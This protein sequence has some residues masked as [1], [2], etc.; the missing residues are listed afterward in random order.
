MTPR[1]IGWFL[2]LQ[3]VWLTTTAHIAYPELTLKISVNYRPDLIFVSIWCRLLQPLVQRCRRHSWTSLFPSVRLQQK[4][5]GKKSGE[6]NDCPIQN[7]SADLRVGGFRFWFL[8]DFENKILI[9]VIENLWSHGWGKVMSKRG[10]RT[11]ENQRKTRKTF[12]GEMVNPTGEE[13]GVPT[14]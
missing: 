12:G 7:N 14:S 3:D 13:M 4:K 6:K 1:R 8:A 11:I 5:W 10:F 2:S 9:V